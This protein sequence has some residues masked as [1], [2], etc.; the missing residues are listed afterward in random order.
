LDERLVIPSELPFK[1]LEIESAIPSHVPLEV[2][3]A[4]IL[5]PR[6]SMTGTLE[7]TAAGEPLLGT[8]ADE[9]M[10]VPA[11]ARLA[12][13]DLSERVPIERLQE[14]EL[15]EPDVFTT[16]QVHFLPKAISEMARHW[17]WEVPTGAVGFHAVLVLLMI[18]MVALFPHRE[19]TQEEIDLATR[20]LGIVYLPDSMFSTPKATP[21]PQAPSNKLRV[22]PR[23]IQNLAPPVIPS[24]TPPAV[25]PT[26]RELP[27]APVAPSQS[28]RPPERSQ[29]AIRM[30]APRTV[31]DAPTPKLQAPSASRALDQA[32][33]GAAERGGSQ[34]STFGGPAP[35][36]GRGGGG[37]GGGGAGQGYM[38]GAVQML[39]PDEG[40][41]FSSYLARVLASVKRNWYAIIPDSARMGEKGRVILDFKIM[42][43]GNVPFPEPI[44]RSTSGKDPLDRAAS[45]SIRASSP[46]EPLPP[47]FSGPYIELRFIFLYNLPLEAQ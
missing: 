44:L 4:R 43:D 24:P 47:A 29:D 6:E 20:N 37:G 34:G 3:G 26:P 42:R 32:I 10:A 31:P 41:D 39:T 17:R 35:G 23:I 38:G 18:A 9:R 22:D 36:V 27:N 1:P 5:I 40:V 45:S 11:D 28:S 8:D 2:L 16:G 46:F 21:R 13:L 25:A 7:V 15:V 30:E 33:R 12:E 19:P 14:E